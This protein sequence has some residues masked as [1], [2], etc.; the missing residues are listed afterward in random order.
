[1]VGRRRGDSWKDYFTNFKFFSNDDDLRLAMLEN[2]SKF[3]AKVKA[4][5]AKNQSELVAMQAELDALNASDSAENEKTRREANVERAMNAANAYA[6][7]AQAKEA[8]E[9]ES[10]YDRER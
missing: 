1:M 8:R 9:N 7:D 2:D 6:Q 4:A 10:G 5:E 3:Q